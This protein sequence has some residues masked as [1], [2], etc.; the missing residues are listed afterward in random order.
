MLNFDTARLNRIVDTYTS[1]LEGLTTRMEALK[2]PLDEAYL[3]APKF[4]AGV[5][6]AHGFGMR[7]L[8]DF[9]GSQVWLKVDSNG[10][11]DLNLAANEYMADGH[12]LDKHVGKTDEQLAHAP[13]R[14][15]VERPD[16]G[17]A[18]R[19]A[20]DRQFLGLPELPACRGTDRVQPQQEQGR[21]RGMD[22][23]PA[24]CVRRRGQVVLRDGTQR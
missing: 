10:S 23:G 19:K 6:R 3:S 4:E 8:E 21:H 24:A 15:A 14:P 18:V 9:K 1:I 2:E 17:L 16:A 7:A 11:Y 20:E 12:T 13:A 5:A 22:Q